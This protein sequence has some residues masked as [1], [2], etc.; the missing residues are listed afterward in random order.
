MKKF[1]EHLPKT[2]DGYIK[3][4]FIVILFGWNLVEGAVYENAYPL[5]MIHVYPLAIWRIMLLVLIVLASDWS[6]HV[7]LLL[8]YMVFFYI[9]DLEV[10]I[11]KW[12]LA[13]LQK[14]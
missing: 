10:T 14:K 9:M 8:I 13:D 4:L 5:A 7:T 11:E 12:S 1:S 3:L 6:A 2:L